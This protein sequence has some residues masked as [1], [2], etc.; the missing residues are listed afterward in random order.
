[1][2]KGGVKPISFPL[3]KVEQTANPPLII[4]VQQTMNLSSIK[5][6]QP[7]NPHLIK[8]R[9]PANPPLKKGGWGDYP[10]VRKEARDEV[11]QTP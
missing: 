11:I 7:M 4:K 6:Q 3:I 5:V 2:I 10:G 1:L 9:L 8:V